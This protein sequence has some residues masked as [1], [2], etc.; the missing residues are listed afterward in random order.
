[1][2]NLAHFKEKLEKE[3]AR[4]ELELSSIG[5]RNPNNPSD[6]EAIVDDLDV[7]PA[8]ENEVADVF[9]ELEENKSIITQLEA[10]LRQVDS[11]LLKMEDK[12]FG[13]CEVCGK[14][15]EDIRLEANPSAKTCMEHI[16]IIV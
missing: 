4:L 2:K 7:L 12:N 14:D 9:E 15:I 11:A 6:W 5:R 10:Q 13:V 8:D 3:K 16:K 1:M